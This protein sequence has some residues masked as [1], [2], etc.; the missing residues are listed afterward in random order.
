VYEKYASFLNVPLI[1]FRVCLIYDFVYAV[2]FIYGIIP[3][4][5]LTPFHLISFVCNIYALYF[6]S[7]LIVMVER[8]SK[9]GFQ[10]Y[11]G[12]FMAAW[13]YIIG[14]WFLQPRVNR[15]FLSRE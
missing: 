9:V 1:R 12:T 5:Y 3:L 2:L 7:K 4:D 11:F 6:I 10:D 8:K 14:V 15:I 13:F